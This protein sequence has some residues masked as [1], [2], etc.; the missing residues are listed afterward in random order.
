MY[1][2][3]SKIISIKKGFKKL[4]NV[5]L[6][7]NGELSFVLGGR[8]EELFS[9][10]L[11]STDGKELSQ[12]TGRSYKPGLNKINFTG[13]SALNRV[14]LVTAYGGKQKITMLLHVLK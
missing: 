13:S 3:Y 14:V 10:K 12:V 2:Q 9:F 8:Q 6:K 7:A 5:L 11:L 4:S 1:Y